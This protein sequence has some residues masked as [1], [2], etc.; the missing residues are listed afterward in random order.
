MSK[1]NAK[2]HLLPS[3][4]ACFAM[5][6]AV[7]WLLKFMRLYGFTVMGFVY[8]YTVMGLYGYGVIRLWGYTVMRV[9]YGFTVMGVVHGFTIMS[10][11]R[12]D[13]QS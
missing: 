11:V 13:L 7:F 6:K 4:R 3:E 9:V 2:G 10:S 8:G 5:R 1:R 12:A